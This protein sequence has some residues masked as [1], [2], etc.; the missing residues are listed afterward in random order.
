[1]SEPEAPPLHVSVARAA[2]LGGAA[3]LCAWGALLALSAWSDAQGEP[4]ALE[5]GLRGSVLV[6]QMMAGAGLVLASD[7]ARGAPRWARGSIRL[8]VLVPVLV[9]ARLATRPAVVVLE[10]L[11]AGRIETQAM[12]GASAGAWEMIVDAGYPGYTVTWLMYGAL[13]GAALLRL[14]PHRA[15]AWAQALAALLFGWVAGPLFVDLARVDER[16]G[17]DALACGTFL[18]A[19]PTLVGALALL[20]RGLARC[21]ASWGAP[22]ARALAAHPRPARVTAPGWVGWSVVG[23]VGLGLVR[24]RGLRDLEQHLCEGD[25]YAGERLVQR[26]AAARVRALVARDGGGGGRGDALLVLLKLDEL[27][28]LSVEAMLRA[29]EH[30]S[31]WQRGLAVEQ[32]AGDRTGGHGWT[33]EDELLVYCQPLQPGAFEWWPIRPARSQPAFRALS[34]ASQLDAALWT[35]RDP[36]RLRGALQEVAALYWPRIGDDVC[37]HLWPGRGR[38][39]LLSAR[40]RLLEAL[41][42]AAG[43][44]DEQA[45]VA[46]AMCEPAG[47]R[48]RALAE[49]HPR[50][51]IRLQMAAILLTSR[52]EH[53]PVRRLVEDLRA[54]LP[55]QRSAFLAR[56]P[57]RERS[58]RPSGW[59]LAMELSVSSGERPELGEE[60]LADPQW[61]KVALGTSRDPDLL[62]DTLLQQAEQS[63][64]ALS[65]ETR[66]LLA[67]PEK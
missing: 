15:P 16:A 44:G 24:E 61:L 45:Q 7:L 23:L 29:L 9:V 19:L 62:R 48:L 51:E 39:G 30:A 56:L 59:S 60:L 22:W 46:L 64:L 37:A 65:P 11:L 33:L 66:A 5:A 63:A 36:E 8:A 20:E 43:A 26:G 18:V 14:A 12:W 47:E 2:L 17:F 6:V 42:I 27:G 57:L 4:V 13:C 40:S 3:G 49:T 31:P 41:E 25:R 1:M 52:T 32:L 53:L 34:S 28:D 55:E 67:R 54:A 50:L 21:A 38:A 35:A 10:Q 58:W